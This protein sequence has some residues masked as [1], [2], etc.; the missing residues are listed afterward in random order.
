[1]AQHH[2]DL[3]Y[4]RIAPVG[5]AS[6]GLSAALLMVLISGV[7]DVATVRVG[8]FATVL[9]LGF[10]ASLFFRAVVW[11]PL[12]VACNVVLVKAARAFGLERRAAITSDGFALILTGAMVGVTSRGAVADPAVT[13]VWVAGTAPIA[14]GLSFM[15]FRRR[16]K[17]E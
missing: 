8:V 2:T 10:L 1:M 11:L 6:T 16:K 7:G 17:V 9:G 15:A 4:W 12:M 14:A 13:I 3:F 5:F